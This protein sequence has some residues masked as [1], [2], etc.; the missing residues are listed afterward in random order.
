MGSLVGFIIKR[1]LSGIV[2]V[3]TIVT[4]VFFLE[5][6]PGAPDPIRGILGAHFTYGNYNRLLHEYGLDV[7]LW[8]QYLNYLGMAPILSWFGVHF[9]HGAA[10]TGLIEGNFG[11]SYYQVGTPVWSLMRDGIPVTL[12]LGVYA[13]IVSLV[14]GIP[15]GLISAIRQNSW[16]DHLLQG[17]SIILYGIPTFVLAPTLQLI[18]TIQNQW[19]PEHG[20]GDNSSEIILPVIVYSA[21]LLGYFAKSFRSFMLEVLQQDYIRTARAK[22][23]RPSVIVWLHAMKNTLLPLASIVGPTIA[24]LIVGAFIIEDFFGIPGIAHIT[25]ESVGTGDYAVIEG[26]TIALAMF[27]VFIN[28]MTDIFYSLVDPRVRL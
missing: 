3:W 2:V 7:P 16:L 22:G 1:V 19:L 9:G 25:I 10:L 6:A 18:F 13:L 15:I 8:Q 11:Y 14:L 26:T 27:V 20:W 21:G 28:M 4:I 23:L 24:F 5:H 17:T 12:K